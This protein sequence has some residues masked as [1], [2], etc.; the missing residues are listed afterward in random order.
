MVDECTVVDVEE[1]TD[2]ELG[3]E[4]EN[5]DEDE[6]IMEDDDELVGVGAEK[7]LE[8]LVADGG[9]LLLVGAEIGAEVEVKMGAEVGLSL[10]IELELEIEKVLELGAVVDAGVDVGRAAL[11]LEVLLDIVNWLNTSLPECLYIVMSA[12]L[13]FIVLIVTS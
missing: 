6:E 8:E 4:E 9:S 3:V 2:D 11:A 1:I 10:A 7:A 13:I 12:K 5:T